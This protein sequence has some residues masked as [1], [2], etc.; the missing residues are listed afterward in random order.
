MLRRI[1]ILLFSI[2]LLG[3]QVAVFAHLFDRCDLIEETKS[4]APC[5]KACNQCAPQAALFGGSLPPAAGLSNIPA[6]NALDTAPV[7]YPAHRP[8]HSHL[9]RAPPP[10]APTSR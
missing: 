2:C 9:S 4:G 5:N 1:V 8:C 10:A 6:T 7:V 3:M